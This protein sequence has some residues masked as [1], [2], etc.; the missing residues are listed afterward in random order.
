MPS[1]GARRDSSRSVDA[2]R[3]GG[4]NSRRRSAQQAGVEITRGAQQPLRVAPPR[5]SHERDNQ[6]G[7]DRH[8]ETA[9]HDPD[10]RA[11]QAQLPIH[12][13]DARRRSD[14]AIPKR[15]ICAT[16]RGQRRRREGGPLTRR[17]P[18]GLQP[19]IAAWRPRSSIEPLT[20][21]WPR[22]SREP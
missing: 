17:Q 19:H 11:P 3:S 10:G 20:I 14:S 18:R 2:I 5:H 22:L 12:D 15:R 16:D 1:E 9:K 4:A 6:R 13:E 7:F 8:D 21:L